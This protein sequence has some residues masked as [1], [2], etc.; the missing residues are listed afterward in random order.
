MI[1]TP[2]R[3]N[4]LN[5]KDW[6]HIIHCIRVAQNV[7]KDNAQTAMNNYNTATNSDY[8]NSMSDLH[9]E[10]NKLDMASEF[11]LGKLGA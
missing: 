2:E 6:E 9:T 3:I 5:D 10:W 4:N 8:R 1:P 7:F 11:A